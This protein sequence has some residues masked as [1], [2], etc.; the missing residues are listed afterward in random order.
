MNFCLYNKALYLILKENFNEA[1]QILIKEKKNL[2][3]LVILIELYF[4]MGK[5]K[6]P[7]YYLMKTKTNKKFVLQFQVL[8]I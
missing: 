2:K 5:K 4:N 7:N 3:F 1:I 8:D 6:R